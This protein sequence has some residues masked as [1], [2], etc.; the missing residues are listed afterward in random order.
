VEN[1]ITSASFLEK[2][3]DMLP[4]PK[5]EK[6]TQ[7]KSV[8]R[9]DARTAN[10]TAEQRAKA[11]STIVDVAQKRG[12]IAAGIVVTGSS[13]EAIG[14]SEGLFRYHRE[15]HAEVSITM[16]RIDPENRTEST[17][18]AKQNSPKASDLD[19]PA[20][21]ARAA[22]KALASANPQDIEPGKYTVILEPSAVLDLLCFMDFDF[23][24]TS[25]VD[26]LSCFLRKQ[27]KKV[28]G[29][30]ITIAD[31][32]YHPLQAGAPF[33]GE[34]LQ[35]QMVELVSGGK[36]DNLVYGRRSAAKLKAKATGHGLYE[37]SAEGEW[38]HNIVIAGGKDSVEQMIKSTKRGILLTRVWYV[39][40]VDPT[41]KIVT[42]MTR[43]GTFLIEG[44]AIKSGIKN[45]RFN[46]SLIEMLNHVVA[47]SPSVRATG[48]EGEPAVVPAMKVENFNFSST[49]AF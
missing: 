5:P 30:N 36:I 37:P 20:L 42:G 35:R 18:W 38:P 33:D 16:K 31:D 45:L 46:Q 1:A 13:A 11:V 4:L 26:K 6:K 27:G 44:G 2:D 47:L 49:T 24:G 7:Q 15:T 21:A 23:T 29:K 34:G 32:V 28:L 22:E 39:R 19:V 17:G 10:F 9:Y 3:E 25:F 14:N 40:E 48:E 43:D 8:S 12:L 41:T